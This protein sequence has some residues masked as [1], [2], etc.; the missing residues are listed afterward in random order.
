MTKR[1][2]LG[3]LTAVLLLA[4]ALGAQQKPIP[5]VAQQMLQNLT[6][7]QIQAR[8]Q[9][10]GLTPAQIRDRLQRAGY[11]PSL[12][13]AY[14]GGT[15]TTTPAQDATFLQELQSI[16]VLRVGG[17]PGV[18]DTLGLQGLT[19]L[20]TLLQRT[21]TS[22]MPGVPDT[23]LHVFG[24]D[25][26]SRQTT[27]FN[28]VLTGPVGPDYR[29]G[30]GDQLNLILTGDVELAYQLDV[31]REGYIV[32]PD[33]GQ[34]FVNG[35]TLGRL[36]D[37][38][39]TR[40]GK[41]YSGVKRTPNATTHFE[42]S[43]GA[44]RTNQVYVVGDVQ[45]PG[46]YQVS[47]VATILEALYA[48]GGPTETG[49]FRHV[50]LRR[51]DK[52]VGEFDLYRY[53]TAGE[54]PVQLRLEEGDVVFVP[55]VGTQVALRGEVRRPALY[56]MLP[57]EGLPDLVRYAGGLTPS[58]SQ[59]RIQVDRILPVGQRRNGRDREVLDVD[60][61]SVASGAEA[62]P[63]HAGDQVQVF[64]V[65][66]LRRGWVRI[67]GAV[68][69]PGQYELQPR[70]TVASLVARAGGP[71]P[72]VLAPILHLSRLDTLNGTRSLIRGSLAAAGSLPLEEYD[73]VTLFGQDSLLVPDS[74]SVY[75]LVQRPGTYPL[76]K[77]MNSEDLILDA[78]GFAE[79]ADPRQAEVV[80]TRGLPSG[81][82]HVA[83]SIY[84][85]LSGR[86]PYPD[87]AAV[88][89][90]P[91]RG[92]DIVG[93]PPAVAASTVRLQP[94]DEVFVRQLPNYR[95]P[96][97]VAVTGEVREPGI[98][99]LESMNERLASVIQRAGGLTPQ[100]FAA[101]IR[102]IRDSVTVATDVQ[103]AL[104]NPGGVD[105]PV[106]AA[107]DSVVVPIYDPTVLVTGA[108]QFSTRVTYRKGMNLNDVL[109]AAGGLT[110][111]ADGARTSVGYANGQRRTLKRFL[112]MTY[113]TP[114]IQP[115]SSVF[116][117]RK[118]QGGPGF[119]WNQALTRILAVTS[120][121]AT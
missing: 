118:V 21:D 73:E 102:L 25:V 48:A 77:G 18:S 19:G 105:D 94:G 52:E 117:P 90:L 70:S 72:D 31:S 30:P 39:Y 88:D 76:E 96:R 68:Y 63:L 50:I 8:I 99:V 116:V 42:V 74:V 82:G 120:T 92:A 119:D 121:M 115:G 95:P 33:V 109:S 84:V 13:D 44:L 110:Q 104:E 113:S 38:L 34:V 35:L 29:L 26:F 11:D 103:R 60:Y 101:G 12:L 79:S 47:S 49:S 114:S 65:L 16:G 62:F 9:A 27:Q 64:P 53:L 22:M 67:D 32:I 106:L 108:V 23:T 20:D 111:D 89:S 71:L 46:A 41:V 57:G 91:P 14:L 15:T 75:G 81:N 97:R 61:D 98:Y 59:S 85:A 43:L 6:P 112:G 86:I 1:A 5:G 36:R 87:S 51:G 10:S 100:A 107:G 56:E 2:W 58:A 3:S 37:E 54:T 7:Q 4:S 55:P 17:L 40:L 45:R 66:N 80:R 78:G 69:R 28:P 93:A 24:M 83:R